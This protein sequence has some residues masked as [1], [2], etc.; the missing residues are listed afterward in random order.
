[1]LIGGS[2]G[3]TIGYAIDE[4]FML[5]ALLL[6]SI[7]CM[8]YTVYKVFLSRKDG[9]YQVLLGAV[10]AFTGFMWMMFCGFV[11]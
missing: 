2:N 11:C 5:L 10:A 4:S 6:A 3:F 8:C 9:D 1:M 7:V